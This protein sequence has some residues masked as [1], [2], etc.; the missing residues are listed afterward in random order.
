MHKTVLAAGSTAWIV[1]L[2]LSLFFYGAGAKEDRL[3]Q[4]AAPIYGFLKARLWF[5]EIY[6]Y[7]V[8]K[9]QQ[10][11]AIFLSFIDVFVIKGIFVRG[12]AGLVGLVG[13]CSRSLHDGNIH[14]YVYWFLAG[15]LALWAAASG[16]L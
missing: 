1:G 4:K 8:A 15:L 5:D 14:S 7:Y 9:I 3:E 2:M 16:I 11:L 12:S 10:R 13:I 6:G